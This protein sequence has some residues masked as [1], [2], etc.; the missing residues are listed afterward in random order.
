MSQSDGDSDTTPTRACTRTREHP[1]APLAPPPSDPIIT[2]SPFHYAAVPYDSFPA[3][4]TQHNVHTE[5]VPF[6]FRG[7]NPIEI[8]HDL[9][10]YLANRPPYTQRLSAHAIYNHF[11]RDHQ[12]VRPEVPITTFM[13]VN[14]WYCAGETTSGRYYLNPDYVHTHSDTAGTAT[15]P[16]ARRALFADAARLGTLSSSPLA[17]AMGFRVTGQAGAKSVLKAADRLGIEWTEQRLAGKVTTART[18][19]LL[20]EWGYTHAAIGRAFCMDQSTVT[21]WIHEFAAEFEPPSDPTIGFA[22]S[23][24]SHNHRDRQHRRHKHKTRNRDNARANGGQDR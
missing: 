1:H 21:R 8:L 9:A 4:G 18:W 15:T 5:L 6:S 22:K 23:P 3:F 11:G 20:A 14:G 19:K 13:L 10:P 2:D 12:L 24:P 7:F 16:E 17:P